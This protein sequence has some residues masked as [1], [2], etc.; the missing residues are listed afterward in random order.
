MLIKHDI[1]I[2]IY[3]HIHTHTI[4]YKL[5]YTHSLTLGEDMNQVA[6]EVEE[7]GMMAG[8]S[9]IMA[10]GERKHERKQ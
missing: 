7:E 5:L 2:Y 6:T 9:R 4:K 8:R 1:Y 10:K 3:T